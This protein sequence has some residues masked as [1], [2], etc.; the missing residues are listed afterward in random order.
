MFGEKPIL[1]SI[2][3]LGRGV[4]TLITVIKPYALVL[5]SKCSY[6]SFACMQVCLVE[7]SKSVTGNQR[8]DEYKV[9]LMSVMIY[10]AQRLCYNY[11]GLKPLHYRI[12]GISCALERRHKSSSL[13]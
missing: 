10:D 6:E 3:G 5:Q 7:I 12:S 9:R 11:H 2:L 13:L 8:K 4:K 1:A